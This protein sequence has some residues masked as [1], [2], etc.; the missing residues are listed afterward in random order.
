MAPCSSHTVC[1]LWAAR[2]SRSLMSAVARA[3]GVGS[4]SGFTS[5]NFAPFS[6]DGRR[7]PARGRPVL[8]DPR[9]G[10]CGGGGVGKLLD[11]QATGSGAHPS[12]PRRQGRARPAAPCRAQQSQ[13]RTQR[14]ARRWHERRRIA[15]SDVSGPRDGPRAT[16]AHRVQQGAEERTED[17]RGGAGAS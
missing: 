11:Q 8:G 13:E 3:R 15:T 2:R 7:L 1:V 5:S 14:C 17:D 6:D 16:T 9:V 12:V 4:H 10:G